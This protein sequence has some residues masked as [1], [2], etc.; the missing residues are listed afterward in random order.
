MSRHGSGRL[1]LENARLIDGRGDHGIGAV[2]V[3]GDRLV[4]RGAASDADERIDLGGRVLCPAFI[5][6]HAHLRDPGHEVKEDLASGLS[7]AAAGGYGTVVSMANTDPAVDEPGI[8]ADLVRRAE[9]L[10][11]TRLRPAAALSHGLSGGRITDFAALQDAGAVMIT[12]DGL[13]VTDAH[14]MR[15]ACEYA[16]ELGLVIQTHSEDPSLRRDGVMN[17]GAVSHRLGLPG[18]P[19]AAEAAMIYR[20]CEI[21]ALTGARVHIAHVSSARGLRVVRWFKEQGAPITCEVTPHHLTLTDAALE[22]FDP[23]YK[24]APPLRTGV[25]ACALREALDTGAVDC[26]GTDHAPHTRAEKERD[27]LEAPFGIANIE[28]AFPLLYTRLVAEGDL[29]LPQLIG[30]FTTGPARVMDWRVPLLESGADADLVV[31]DLHSARVVRGTD[32]QSKAKFGPWEGESLRGWPVA[33]FVR[34]TLVFGAL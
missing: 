13:P 9:R 33:T 32:F 24:V 3:E 11:G 7:A 15:R 8:V 12:D 30:L 18:N 25:D 17:E 21:A 26:I 6:L 28:V 27:L 23:I 22:S 1:V 20:D 10:R 34:G 2:T 31:L 19:I 5:D 4:S 29:G 16:A 14:L